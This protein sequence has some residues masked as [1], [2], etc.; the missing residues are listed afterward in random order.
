MTREA[1]PFVEGKD[2]ARLGI[3]AEAN[4]YPAGSDKHALWQDGHDLAAGAV[5]ASESEGR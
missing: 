1:D 4:P 5:E 2:A 3:P